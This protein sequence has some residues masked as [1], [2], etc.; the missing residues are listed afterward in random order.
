[1]LRETQAI[2]AM[3]LDALYPERGSLSIE[4]THTQAR[5]VLPSIIVPFYKR[6][7]KV[8]LHLQ[9]GTSKQIADMLTA[10]QVDIAISTRARERLQHC[11]LPPCYEWYR[12]VIAPEQY[13]LARSKTPTLAKLVADP[14]VT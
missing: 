9:Q 14:L 8:K 5:Y 3:S 11:I 1:M 12:R 4:T 7:P 13:S 10:G 2:R 6:Y